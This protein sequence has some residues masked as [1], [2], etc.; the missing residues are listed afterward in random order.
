[1]YNKVCRNAKK[2]F[3]SGK[4]DEFSK[5]G[6]KTWDTVREVLKTKKR[7]E[8]VPNFF[9]DH[10]RILTDS[11]EIAVGFNKFFAGIGPELA[12]K[13]PESNIP[14][15]QFLGAQIEEDFIFFQNYTC[16]TIPNSI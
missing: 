6:R 13:I 16:P 14:F 12:S 7:R 15:D 1:M 3:Y 2:L 5:N 9:K 4:F 8:N 11:N 10:G